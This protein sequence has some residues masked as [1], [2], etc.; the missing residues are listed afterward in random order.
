V[1]KPW[2]GKIAASGATKKLVSTNV[3][4]SFFLLGG[5]CKL[6]QL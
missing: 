5:H 2:S 6:P 3:L 4:S 1:Q